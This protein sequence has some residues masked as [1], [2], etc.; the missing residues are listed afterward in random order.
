MRTQLGSYASSNIAANTYEMK[1]HQIAA[2]LGGEVNQMGLFGSRWAA[3]RTEGGTRTDIIDRLQA[4]FK[5]HGIKTK[6]T[7]EGNAL[8]R[9]SVL[10]KDIERAKELMDVFDKEQ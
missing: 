5:S 6:I 8:K 1:F 3:I 4:L 2:W 9:I 10:K 7:T